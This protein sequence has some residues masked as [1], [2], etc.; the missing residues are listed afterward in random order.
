MK[1]FQP[2]S[3]AEQVAEHLRNEL[4]RGSFSEAFPSVY[5]LASDLGVNHKT[6]KAAIKV[7]ECEGLLINQGRG[8]ARKVVESAIEPLEAMR[9][10]VFYY[11]S[12][13]ASQSYALDLKQAL[14]EKGYVPVIVPKT[15]Q[16]DF[17]MN[18]KRIAKFA[19]TFN[20]DAWIVYA[21]SSEV[22]EWFAT[23]G[24]P[25]FAIYG[26]LNA[27]DIAGV[28]VRKSEVTSEVLKRLVSYGHKRI[29]KIVRAERRKPNYGLP[30]RLFLEE[31][32]SHGISTSSYNIPDWEE[33]PGGLD[34]LLSNLFRVTP[35][36]A[37]II[38]DAVLFH[39]VQNH[40]SRRGIN[41]PEDI[42]FFCNDYDE[43][44]DWVTPTI[45]HLKWDY[46]PTIRRAVQWLKN[47]SE[48]QE[49]TNVS[50]YNAK[51]IEGETI[52]HAP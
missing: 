36:T 14:V 29:V 3:V 45:T 38:G 41:A 46:R 22:L 37:L 8:C 50:Y 9:V 6:V 42:S 7:L 32:E 43:C 18:C 33:S 52:G 48:R 13:T 27:V 47:I 19:Q 5:N 21:G 25:S 12:H 31:L 24:V 11:D 17:K 35:P 26:R 20:V 39:S 28:A 49:D 40:L 23:S 15:L 10:G 44:F 4:K 51:L 30:E 34:E 16:D 1:D 2:Q